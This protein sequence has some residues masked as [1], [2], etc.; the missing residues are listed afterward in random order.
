MSVHAVLPPLIRTQNLP[1]NRS[2][3]YGGRTG[4]IPSGVG[5]NAGNGCE[6][7]V[8][9]YVEG[10]CPSDICSK[11]PLSPPPTSMPYPTLAPLPSLPPAPDGE[12][13]CRQV[14]PRAGTC[15]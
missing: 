4:W 10:P 2:R 13:E 6:S 3:S 1:K 14:L 9:N 5:R 8:T 12:L 15:V 7:V 11:L